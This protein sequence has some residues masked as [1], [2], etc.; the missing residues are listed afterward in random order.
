MIHLR[1]SLE[2][3]TTTIG[4]FKEQITHDFSLVVHCRIHHRECDWL[5]QGYN[6][7]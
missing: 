7:K 6:K 5:K 3:D 2:G 1:T 4:F